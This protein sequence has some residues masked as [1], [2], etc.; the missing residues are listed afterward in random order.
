MGKQQQRHVLKV[1]GPKP[2]VVST[3]VTRDPNAVTREP[4]AV[5]RL[6]PR[7]SAIHVAKHEPRQLIHAATGVLCTIRSRRV[8]K[9]ISVKDH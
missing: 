9:S 8:V 5:T 7:E 6:Q 2:N 3:L 4:N 1:L